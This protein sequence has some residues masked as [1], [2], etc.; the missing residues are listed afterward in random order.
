MKELNYSVIIPHYDSLEK[1]RRLIESI[2]ISREDIEI[3]IIDDN[4]ISFKKEYLI[5]ENLK[6]IKVF[7]NLSGK[8]GAGAC[9]NIGLEKANGKWLV[10]ADADDYFLEN[11]FQIMDKYLK[12]KEEIIYFIPTSIYENTR[13]EA[14]RHI[15]FEKLI[16][17]FLKNPTIKNEK[18]LRFEFGVPW[19]KMIKRDLVKKNSIEFDETIII[20]DRMFSLKTGYMSSKILAVREKIYCVTRDSGSL[21]TIIDEKVY[22][23]KIEVLLNINKF[24]IGI[25]EKKNKP[26]MIGYLMSS[27]EYGLSKFIKVSILLLKNKCKIFPNNFIKDIFSGFVY[28]K[29]LERKKDKKYRVKNEYI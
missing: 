10:F 19:S 20:N 3:L 12:N 21:T 29:I 26:Y 2:P 25:N 1:L 4:S 13:R 18:E 9:R 24:V 8:K 28:K 6:N 27:R 22:D 23:V 14:N 16:L 11:A 17:D 5:R 7:R 15:F